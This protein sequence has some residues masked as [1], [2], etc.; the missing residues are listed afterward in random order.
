VQE[1]RKLKVK[2][3]KIIIPAISTFLIQYE[4]AAAHTIEENIDISGINFSIKQFT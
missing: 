3:R 2:L 4:Y 1:T